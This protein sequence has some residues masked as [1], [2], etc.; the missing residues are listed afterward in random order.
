[1]LHYAPFSGRTSGA[2]YIITSPTVNIK[3]VDTT[4]F[5]ISLFPAKQSAA[6]ICARAAD[7]FQILHTRSKPTG[8]WCFLWCFLVMEILFCWLRSSSWALLPLPSRELS[9][10]SGGFLHQG[11]ATSHGADEYHPAFQERMLLFAEVQDGL[12]EQKR[13]H[14]GSQVGTRGT[15]P[16]ACSRDTWV[17][18]LPTLFALVLLKN[19]SSEDSPC[20]ITPIL[21]WPP[22]LSPW[23]VHQWTPLWAPWAP[24][25]GWRAHTAAAWWFSWAPLYSSSPQW[26]TISPKPPN[27]ERGWSCCAGPLPSTAS[28]REMKWGLVPHPCSPEP[29]RRAVPPQNALFLWNRAE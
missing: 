7:Q 22:C 16:L 19:F 25:W 20:G 1:M 10:S 17:A 12:S 6:V 14:L 27:C 11:P 23:G 15:W 2:Q 26:V 24:S 8:L 13:L 9:C 21:S 5:K 4:L 3:K 28:L 18:P 29:R